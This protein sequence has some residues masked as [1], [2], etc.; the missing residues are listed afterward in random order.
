MLL[1]CLIHPRTH[2]IYNRPSWML[3]IPEN[4]LHHPDHKQIEVSYPCLLFA[5]DSKE[6]EQA[7]PVDVIELEHPADPTALVLP[8]GTY[9]LLIRSIEGE[10]QEMMIRVEKKN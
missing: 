6:S 7:V 10:K 3:S 1:R 5:Y 4:K 2:Y 9:R 8:P